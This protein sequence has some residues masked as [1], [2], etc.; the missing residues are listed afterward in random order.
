M[1]AV[2]R[3]IR[4]NI[5]ALSAD[6]VV[7][8][9]RLVLAAFGLVAIYLDPSQ[10]TY[11]AEVTYSILVAYLALAVLLALASFWLPV[12]PAVQV[13]VHLIDIVT[14][15]LVMRFTEGPTS[16]FFVLFTFALL[17]ATLYWGW[18]GAL[19]TALVLVLLL[20]VVA[21]SEGS[22][23]SRPDARID[24]LIIRGS[25]LMVTGAL[26]AYV[27]A[28]RDRTRAELAK[29]AAWP[30]EQVSRAELPPLG[31]SL[32]HAADVMRAR[33]VLVLW[34]DAQEPYVH[35]SLW[36]DGHQHHEQIAA[37]GLEELL[38]PELTPHTFLMK[39][40][41]APSI[42]SAA[43]PR[44]LPHSPISTMLLE[45]FGISGSV[46]T[47]PFRGTGFSGRVFV[48]GPVFLGDDVESLIEIAALRIGIEIEHHHLR[49]EL[50]RAA[51]AEERMR[52]ARD[53]H[54]GTLQ[55]LTAAA[56]RLKNASEA[57]PAGERERLD[58]IRQILSDQQRQLR[59]F[60]T[61]ALEQGPR[62]EQIDLKDELGRILRDIERDWNC[63]TALDVAPESATVTGTLQRQLNLLV[64]EAAAN[65][66]RH[67]QARQIGVAVE[68]NA[69]TLSLRISNDGRPLTGLDG[70]FDQQE[71]ARRNVGPISIRN[72]VAALRGRMLL[73]SD[74]AG[75]ELA[76]ELPLG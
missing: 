21:V 29:L 66:V 9:A 34:E 55:A 61:D 4:T 38:A 41:A 32:A 63:R 3:L 44:Q 46:A 65:A 25:Y 73:S 48:V 10:P 30:A 1:P 42:L 19:G 16:P 14:F 26:L 70:R 40:A 51:A 56:L 68:R 57:A 24:D 69:T 22:M 67:G 11:Y 43:G 12:A 13:V 31:R 45:R 62:E 37:V 76:I 20:I 50:E 28:Y 5:F 75:V 39:D 7:A 23:F 27:G 17:S 35:A 72:R 33:R 58:E 8:T 6:Q 60:V 49:I 47:A 53:V 18:R 2:G 52:I 74:T 71:L 15:S 59:A 54:D 64:T 36:V